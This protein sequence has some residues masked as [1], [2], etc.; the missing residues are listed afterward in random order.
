[1]STSNSETG[2][3]DAAARAAARWCWRFAGTVLAAA[4]AVAAL[5]AAIDWYGLFRDPTGRA[6][7]GHSSERTAKFLLAHRYVGA[8]FDGLIVGTSLTDNWD[9]AQVRA[10]RLYNASLNGGNISEERMLVD[11]VLASGRVHL[12]VFCIHPFLTASIGPKSGEMNPRT[13]RGALGSVELLKEYAHAGMQAAGLEQGGAFLPD[14][15]YLYQAPAADQRAFRA[16]PATAKRAKAVDAPVNE[17]AVAE[18][19][20]L[21]AEARAQGAR[22]AGFIPPMYAPYYEERKALYDAYFVRLRALFAPGE[23]VVDFNAP[24]YAAYDADAG[25]FQDGYHLTAQGAA[26]FSAELG[27]A[28]GS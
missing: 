28:L 13:L 25:N 21:L 15:R 12:V 23:L 1:L 17:A 22:V 6:L 2:A 10:A 20:Q 8:N 26:R 24:P 3:A 14:G 16:D 4:L 7:A 18:Y 5:N 9:P 11:E 27:A 19:A